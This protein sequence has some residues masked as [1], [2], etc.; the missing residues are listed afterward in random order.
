[1]AE[2]GHGNRE[3]QPPGRQGK[4]GRMFERGAYGRSS[5]DALLVRF[6]K[7]AQTMVENDV[8][9][10]KASTFSFSPASNLHL[11]PAGYAFLG[12]FIDHDLT[13]DPMSKL[14]GET[15]AGALA[16]YRTPALDLDSV[17][18]GGPEIAPH[19][20][21]R[22]KYGRF[23]IG[24]SDGVEDLPRN[25]EGI[26]LL[27]DRRNDDNR[28]LSQ[29]HLVFLRFH[30]RIY[31]A[32]SAVFGES[33]RCFAEASMQ[34]RFH[35]QWLVLTDFLERIIKAE[36]LKTMLPT[37][38]MR[39]AS[40]EQWS[41]AL[42]FFWRWSALPYI[43]VEF[44]A[45]A[46]RYGHSALRNSYMLNKDSGSI[47]LF[48]KSGE[49]LRGR[50]HLTRGS[51]I[52]WSYFFGKASR[53][54]SVQTMRSID[55]LVAAGLSGLPAEF[56]DGEPSLPLRTLWRGLALGLPTGQAIA[57]AV[58]LLPAHI[59]SSQNGFSIGPQRYFVEEN[60]KR[61]ADP[62]VPTAAINALQDELMGTFADA[63]PLWY[64]I[65]KEA[66][67]FESGHT[68]GWVGSTI[69]AEVILGLLAA[70]PESFFN[71]SPQ[72]CPLRGRFGCQGDREY[73]MPDL[74]AYA[75]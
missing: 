35:Y 43:A 16:N 62:S 39:R 34:V 23:L 19:L 14:Q 56:V 68:L 64:Y 61:V 12:Q 30:N 48:A 17:Y 18:G 72:W 7:L 36:V 42:R 69:V 66:E 28:I 47:P 4:F 53:D 67:V 49:D 41:P 58:G 51:M 22:R 70:D 60:G 26:A 45:A 21:E 57:R 1:M 3:L 9:V 6:G 20:Y 38:G 37:D 13:F 44:A 31:D 50:R 54:N 8:D 33:K 10:P 52:D 65:L 11:Q 71:A 59:L 15:D 75:G 73:T 29:L 32:L 55:T 27:G 24:C 25:Q 74:L 46:F 63:T 40:P 5:D 2:Y